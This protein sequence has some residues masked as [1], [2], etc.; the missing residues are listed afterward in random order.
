MV[1]LGA[2]WLVRRGGWDG[3]MGEKARRY[4]A[5][6]EMTVV[7]FGWNSRFGRDALSGARCVFLGVVRC[8]GGGGGG[9]SVWACAAAV[10]GH[11]AFHLGWDAAIIAWTF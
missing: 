9:D 7:C 8:G 10:P 3:R 4:Y 11:R 6:R 2:G 5:A 1:L